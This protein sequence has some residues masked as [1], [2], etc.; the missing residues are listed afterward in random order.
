L[1]ATG[2]GSFDQPDARARRYREL[3][4]R[5]GALTRLDQFDPRTDRFQSSATEALFL[6]NNPDAQR[7]VAKNGNN[8]VARLTA[9]KDDGQIV[10]T[11]VWTVL[12][13]PPDTEERTILTRW[14]DEHGPDRSKACGQL[15]WALLTS[16]EF[17]FNH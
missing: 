14:L 4:D 12:S 11:A 17:R 5:A 6:S 1:L 3:E 13:R 8:L 9:L 15:V 10:D 7:L 2:D 16:A